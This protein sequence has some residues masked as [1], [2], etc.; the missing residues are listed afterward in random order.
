[1]ENKEKKRYASKKKI[2]TIK[3]KQENA[4]T[5]AKERCNTSKRVKQ[6]INFTGKNI[7]WKL[8]TLQELKLT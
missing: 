8:R 5:I 6:N 7:K 1:M 2:L 3:Q 4:T